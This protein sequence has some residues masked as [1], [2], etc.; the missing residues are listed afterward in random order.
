M[1]VSIDDPDG[2]VSNPDGNARLV[3]VGPDVTGDLPLIRN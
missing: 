2:D 1:Q 3:G